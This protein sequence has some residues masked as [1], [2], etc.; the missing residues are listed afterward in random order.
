M[1]FFYKD[2]NIDYD[3]KLEGTTLVWPALTLGNIG[4]LT[5]DLLVNTFKCTRI[6][7]INDPFIVPIVGNDSY[8]PNGQGVLSTSVEVYQSPN[9]QIT[10]VQ[11]RAPIIEG[12]IKL[13]A[14]KLHQWIHQQQFKEILFIASTNAN[15]RVDSQLEGVQIR[16]IKTENIC[17]ESIDRVAMIKVPEMERES[18]YM[19][20]VVQLG[21]RLTGLGKELYTLLQSPQST[22]PFLCLNLFCSEGENTIE[23]LEMA[24]FV[25][26]YLD[27]VKVDQTTPTNF[28][29]PNSWSLLQ[30]PTYDQSLFF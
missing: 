16:Y 7:Y 10:I 20:E 3:V 14:K 9:K 13:F 4:Q 15:K 27:F 22:V 21:S 6:G 19:D 2:S 24:D 28:V 18:R 1:S 17:K 12:H 29:T 26:K 5:I 30:G 8:T 11:Q 25:A 23:S